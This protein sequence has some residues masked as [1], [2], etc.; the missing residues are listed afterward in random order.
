MTFVV[1]ETVWT[2]AAPPA[3]R[4]VVTER[5]NLIARSEVS[6]NERVGRSAGQG[7]DHHRRR[8][9]DRARVR[10]TVPRR[11]RQG[12]RRR[13]E[14]GTRRRRDE[15]AR[16]QGRCAIFVQ[17]DISDPDS[18]QHCVDESGRG[19]RHRAH[20]REQRRALLRHRQLRPELR[21]P[22]EGLQR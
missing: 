22:A 19:V 21:V 14:R 8:A 5:F 3:E 20:P 9:G 13:G 12:R 16:G 18:A 10:R 6:R 11:G 17:T 4:P 15:G 7:R 1:M 2:D